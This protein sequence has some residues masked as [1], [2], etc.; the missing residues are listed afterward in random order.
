M[1]VALVHLDGGSAIRL[2]GRGL[3]GQRLAGAQG[4]I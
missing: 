1:P 4:G 2:K 3:P